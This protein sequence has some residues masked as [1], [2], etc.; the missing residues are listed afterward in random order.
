MTRLIA[1]LLIAGTAALAGCNTVSGAGQDI[2]KGGQAISNS[3]E[4]H[5]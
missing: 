1:L 2:S 3:A 5:K 4:Q